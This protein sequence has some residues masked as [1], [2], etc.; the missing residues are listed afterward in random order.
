MNQHSRKRCVGGQLSHPTAGR[1]PVMEREEV[2]TEDA[3]REA[4]LEWR[5]TQTH[6]RAS[7][8]ELTCGR[9]PEWHNCC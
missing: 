3:K 9:H 8:L 4:G 5:L 6:H 7:S 2:R 1:H